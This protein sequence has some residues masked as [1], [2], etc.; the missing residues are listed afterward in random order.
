MV[1]LVYSLICSGGDYWKMPD[2]MVKYGLFLQLFTRHQG[3][4]APSPSTQEEYM[5]PPTAPKASVLS[6]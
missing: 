2:R 5:K 1:G 4:Q 3:V 6:Y